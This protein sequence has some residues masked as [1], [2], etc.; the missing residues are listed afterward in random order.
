M[1]ADHVSDMELGDFVVADIGDLV[2]CCNQVLH[3]GFPLAVPAGNAE[4]NKYLR[5]LGR[6]IPIVE[7]G[8][9]S[10]PQRFA[11][12]QEAPRLLWNH[13]R[14]QRFALGTQIRALGDMPQAIEVHVGTAVYGDQPLA[15]AVLPRDVLLDAGDGKRSGGLDNRACVLEH[16]LDG[17]ADLVSVNEQY[18]I[19]VRT[20]ESE[21]LFADPLDRNAV[22]ENTN[23]IQRHSL[24]G[25]Q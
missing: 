16:I 13:N 15:L 18:L 12:T 5:G 1:A 7:L 10:R 11:E 24:A 3:N 6:L 17:R 21:R 8:D 9:I 19:D 2:V 4:S 20:T 22:G 14:Q 23:T 25:T